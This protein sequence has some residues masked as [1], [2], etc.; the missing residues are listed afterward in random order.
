MTDFNLYDVY[1]LHD[2]GSDLLVVHVEG[3]DA[4]E[5]GEVELVPIVINVEVDPD[6][7]D[8]LLRIPAEDWEKLPAETVVDVEVDEFALVGEDFEYGED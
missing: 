8:R 3:Y 5:N 1:A 7:G 6:T 4:D 2:N